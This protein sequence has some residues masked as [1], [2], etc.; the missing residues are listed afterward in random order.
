M[1]TTFILSLLGAIAAAVKVENNYNIRFNRLTGNNRQDYTRYGQCRF[2]VT[3]NL[4]PVIWEKNFSG[5]I[6]AEQTFDAATTSWQEPSVFINLRRLG[7]QSD[8]DSQYAVATYYKEDYNEL[9]CKAGDLVPNQNS[10]SGVSAD[11]S[12]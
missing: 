10:L 9:R 11:E 3:P 12:G 1:R 6:F 5:V 7:T 8:K 4:N 2:H